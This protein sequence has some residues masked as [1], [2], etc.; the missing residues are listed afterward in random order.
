MNLAALDR[1][2][3][4]Y[5]I[6]I[7][8]VG[9]SAVAKFFLQRGVRVEGSDIQRSPFVEDI[10]ALGGQ[11]FPAPDPDRLTKDIDLVVYTDDC[12]PGHPERQAATQCG[13]VTQ[14]FS[15]TLGLIMEPY[16]H[17]VA[18]SG[19]NGK[20][21]TTAMI[22]LMLRAAG[23]DPSIFVGSRL[24][25]F[26]SNVH[27]GGGD[28]MVAE[29]DEYRDHFLNLHPTMITIANIELD[30][31]D[32]FHDL[33]QIIRSFRRFVDSLPPDGQ[34]MV[35]DDDP[36]SAREFGAHPKAVTFGQ[37]ALSHFRLSGLHPSSGRQEFD[38]TWQGRDLGTFSLLQPGVFNAYNALAAIATTISL[39]VD[40]E[41]CRQTLQSFRGIWRR[42]EILNPNGQVTI[43]N[44]YAHHPTAVAGT[45]AGAREFYP[46][47]RI[48]AVF[49]PHHRHRLTSLFAEF[50]QSFTAADVSIIS[51]VFAVPGREKKE[52]GQK[53]GHDLADRLGARYAA[54]PEAAERMVIKVAKPGDVVVIM[55]AGDIWKIAQPLSEHYA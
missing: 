18:V 51:E 4:V 2:H 20:S 28:I 22:G 30:H 21:T 11:W 23:R 43:V 45:L 5:C 41:I 46:G 16:L 42:F 13:L 26:D 37:S 3:K 24:K 31:T 55:G 27:F 29:A 47:R 38:L 25:E 1:I 40:P 33:A 9:V 34:L 6:G 44:D 52:A 7:G 39:G 35:N 50:G 14:N 8:G 48:V 32:Y 36:V 49:Q 17:R 15:E 19:T 54:N 10:L 12:P 53:T